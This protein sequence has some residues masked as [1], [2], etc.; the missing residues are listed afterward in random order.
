MKRKYASGYYAIVTS[1]NELC[2]WLQ[3]DGI[4][5]TAMIPVKGVDG[6]NCISIDY[7]HKA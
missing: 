5:I 1:I 4:E 2:A 7:I 3:N 6:E